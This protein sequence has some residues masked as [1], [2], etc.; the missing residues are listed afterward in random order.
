MAVTRPQTFPCPVGRFAP[1]PS[2]VLHLGNLRTALASWL[3]VRS[4]GGRW[5]LRME[6]VDR[7]R[8][9]RGL[10]ERQLRDLE[11]L[12]LGWDGPVLWQSDRG[13]AYTGALERLDRE[14]RL[15]RCACSRKDLATMGSA[16]HASEGLR[17]YPGTCRERGWTE[18]AALRCRLPEGTVAWEDRVLGPQM[19]DPARL[20]G[21]PILHRRDGCFAYHLAVVVDDGTQGITEVVR[22]GDL[23]DVTATH[24]RLQE[25]LG[26]PR[27]TYAHLALVSGPGGQRLGKR[28]GALGL[29][30]LAQRGVEAGAVLGWLGY[31]LGCL[32][33][34]EPCRA[35]DLVA[36]FHWETLPDRDADPPRLLTLGAWIAQVSA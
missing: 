22:G 8:C 14:G 2:G 34:P 20:T 35:E 5:I 16:P 32:D 1:S 31:S 11:A 12:G 24:L 3:S 26:L 28:A 17:P 18:A 10:G 33:R 25:A 9:R 23:R 21:D 13:S 36:G 7:A 29:A 4:S 15:Y 19:D 30:E 27:P 6:D